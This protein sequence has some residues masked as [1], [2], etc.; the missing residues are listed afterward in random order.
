MSLTTSIVAFAES[1]S[2]HHSASL[3]DTESVVAFE[4]TVSRFDW[5]NPHVYIYIETQDV[6]HELR[7]LSSSARLTSRFRYDC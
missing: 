4:G 3:F 6:L 2:G 5:T 1:A 7:G